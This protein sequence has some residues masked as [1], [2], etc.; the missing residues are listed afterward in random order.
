MEKVNDNLTHKERISLLKSKK[1][2]ICGSDS[3][4]IV[5]PEFVPEG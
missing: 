4:G 2:L 5:H 3:Q 1:M